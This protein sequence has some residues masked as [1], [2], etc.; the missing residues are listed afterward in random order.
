[1]RRGACTVLV[2]AACLAL[3]RAGGAAP[4]ESARYRVS[5]VAPWNE[6]RA[7]E[8]PGYRIVLSAPDGTILEAAVEI[9]ANPLPDHAPFP[10]R[11]DGL[12]EDVRALL[13]GVAPDPDADALSRL[14][15]RG[16]GTVLE[17]IERVIAFTS[18]RIKYELPTGG[19]PETAS[20]CRRIGRGSCVGRSLLAADLLLRRGVPARQ[21]TGVLF[22]SSPGDLTPDTRPAFSD[23][24]GGVRHRWIEVF[25]P[26]LGWVPSDPGGLANAVSARHVA[27][28]RAPDY[29]FGLLRIESSGEIRWPALRGIG[30][31]VTLARPRSPSIFA[32]EASE[33]PIERLAR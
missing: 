21:V 11:P 28:S 33:L 25:V 20:S 30:R 17:A 19:A 9:D 2:A 5:G 6:I 31:G 4:L 1:M 10:P 23:S 32:R 16:S 14:L 13:S 15:T 27:L 22:A 12:P 7:V 29:D 8:A 3:G 24:L 18:R 26:G